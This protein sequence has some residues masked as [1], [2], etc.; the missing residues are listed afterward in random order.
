MKKN[1]LIIIFLTICLVAAISFIAPAQEV[2]MKRL[3]NYPSAQSKHFI[4]DTNLIADETR[5]TRVKTGAKITT[6]LESVFQE[7]SLIWGAEFQKITI[8]YKSA[9]GIRFKEYVILVSE[10]TGNNIKQWAIKNL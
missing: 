3:C 5:M 6:S 4:K 1:V 10:T 8:T 7:I 9:N 2:P